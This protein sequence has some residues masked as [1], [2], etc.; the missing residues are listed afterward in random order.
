MQ[1]FRLKVKLCLISPKEK[2]KFPLI[3]ISFCLKQAK[4]T[5]TVA[6]LDYAGEYWGGKICKASCNCCIMAFSFHLT[7]MKKS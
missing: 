4:S 3:C 5:L 6:S 7:V 1:Y 2:G